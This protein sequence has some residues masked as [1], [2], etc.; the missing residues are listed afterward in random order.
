MGRIDNGGHESMMRFA[1]DRLAGRDL[2]DIA[3]KVQVELDEGDRNRASL[4]FDT[5]GTRV[6]LS[7]PG[8][9][10]VLQVEQASIS[11]G[12]GASR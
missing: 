1:I 5:F 4:S 12:L 3:L 6:R 11:E 7:C 2:R 10:F 9:S 8:F